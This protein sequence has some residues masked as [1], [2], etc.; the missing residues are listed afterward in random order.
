MKKKQPVP[1]LIPFL[2][3]VSL[4]FI[5]ILVFAYVETR[6]ANPKMI[7]VGWAV[8]QTWIHPGD[9]GA[10]RGARTNP[11]PSEE[12]LAARE[13]SGLVPLRNPRSR[14]RA[15]IRAPSVSEGSTAGE[16]CHAV[17]VLA[18]SGSGRPRIPPRPLL[19][20]ASTPPRARLPENP[21]RAAYCSALARPINS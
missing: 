6:R 8:P 17:A 3:V 19:P 5:G 7:E 15:P 21:A 9:A 14:S 11:N 12:S 20:C 16:P 2:I 1:I 10:A 4:L 13:C 18:G